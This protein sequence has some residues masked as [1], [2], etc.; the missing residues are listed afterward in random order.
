[1][2][3]RD[4][5]RAP[6]FILQKNLAGGPFGLVENSADS[7]CIMGWNKTTRDLWRRVVS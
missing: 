7:C 5:S 6:V 1:M 3:K 2:P 4:M